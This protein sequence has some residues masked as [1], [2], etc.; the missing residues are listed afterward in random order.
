MDHV[1][2]SDQ[3]TILTITPPD[4]ISIFSDFLDHYANNQNLVLSQIYW[5]P[6]SNTSI[7]SQSLTQSII[8]TLMSRAGDR[9]LALYLFN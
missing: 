4:F 6:D 8:F 2:G 9:I 5:Q 1:N 7:A 3:L